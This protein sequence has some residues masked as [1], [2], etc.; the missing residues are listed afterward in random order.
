MIM[1]KLLGICYSFFLDFVVKLETDFLIP[2]AK[3]KI[4]ET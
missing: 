2:E 4:C 3:K 1:L